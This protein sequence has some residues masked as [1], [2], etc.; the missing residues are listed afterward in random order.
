MMLAFVC[1]ILVSCFCGVELCCDDL[2]LP[3]GRPCYFFGVL[4]GSGAYV[5][6]LAF[7]SSPCSFV[8][9]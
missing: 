1:A 8:G 3:F 6:A 5:N 7:V 9:Y 2:L 4:W